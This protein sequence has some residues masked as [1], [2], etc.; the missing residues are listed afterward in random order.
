[1]SAYVAPDRDVGL[2]GHYAGFCT[3]LVSFVIDVLTVVVLFDAAG[4]AV[5]YIVT[6]LSGKQFTVSEYPVAAGIALAAWAIFYCAYTQASSGRTFGMAV[7]G[8]PRRPYRRDAPRRTPRRASRAR[9][10]LELLD[11][12]DRVPPHPGQ[13]GP[14]RL[15]RPCGQDGRGL[16]V[17]RPNGPSAVPGQTKRRVRAPQTHFPVAASSAPLHPIRVISARNRTVRMLA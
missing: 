12:R 2:Q 16:R 15:A 10:S 11:S 7:A 14:P 8:L 9:I 4:K 17:G 6:T 3:R 5:E 13:P 1:M